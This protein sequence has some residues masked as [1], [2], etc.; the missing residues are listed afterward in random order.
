MKSKKAPIFIALLIPVISVV[1][2]LLLVYSKKSNLAG[3]DSFDYK[4]YLN[5]ASNMQGNTYLLK[6]MIKRQLV[7]LGSQGRVVCVAIEGD[8]AE[9]AVLIP[10]NI[11]S[12]VTTNQR[13]NMIV[14]VEENGKVLVNEMQKY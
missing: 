8:S 10:N 4:S 14:R 6:A 12:N 13:Y 2:A 11:A 9:F 5:S 7:N 1:I 3:I